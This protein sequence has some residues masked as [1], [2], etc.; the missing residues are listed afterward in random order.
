MTATATQFIDNPL[1]RDERAH[2]KPA[3]RHF[4]TWNDI[5]AGDAVRVEG[6][7]GKFTFIAV[8]VVAGE[9]VHAA[10]RGE[11]GGGTRF[12]TPDRV[13]KAGK[14]RGKAVAEVVEDDTAEDDEE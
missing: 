5:N 9:P 2:H 11:N 6:E 7:R 1:P 3:W 13:T 12:F 8:G 4:A 10:V 14:R